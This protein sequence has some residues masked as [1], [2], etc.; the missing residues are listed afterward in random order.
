MRI[1]IDAR[2]VGPDGAGLG[3]YIERL[4]THLE[5]LDHRN[6]YVVF[7][8]SICP[9][10]P[11]NPRWKTVIA[12]I[13]WYTLAEQ[14]K[15]PG[16][17]RRAKLDLLHLPHFNFPI[18]YTGK[19]VLTVHDLILSD[20]PTERTS[21]LE[22]IVFK[23]KLAAYRLSLTQAI[24]RA[25]H[26]MT[27]SRW[28]RER[29]TAMYPLATGKLSVTYEAA[30]PLPPPSG[31]TEIR[32]RG[33]Q[34]PYLLYVGNAYPHKNLERLLLATKQAIANGEK[35][36]LVI[37]GK[38]DFFS[39]RLKAF[40]AEHDCHQA[41]F[42]GYAPDAEYH[43]L[44]KQATAYFFPSLSEGFG[45]PGL[46]A[47]TVGTP[48][49]AARASCLPEIYGPAAHYFDPQSNEDII[50]AVTVA[51]HDPDERQRLITAGAERVRGYSWERMA[52][53][54]LS[55]YDTALKNGPAT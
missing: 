11:T 31:E 18:L 27:V 23:L 42:Y 30:D 26:I 55:V 4:L 28:S 44:L 12:D 13:R 6:D 51:L 54:T 36:Q 19:F 14:L 8:R 20:F 32:A 16:I 29:V 15:M 48:V 45:L 37:V 34:A 5:R 35:F 53:Q 43:Q 49:F 39:R 25:K 2:F 7:V 41:I 40:A 24:R 47:M 17:F 3:R 10:H 22:P 52:Q 38:D 21:T 33:I 46:E 9:W 50:R 1:G